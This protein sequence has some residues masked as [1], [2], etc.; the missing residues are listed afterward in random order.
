MEL[1]IISTGIFALLCIPK[2]QAFTP[3]FAGAAPVPPISISTSTSRLLSAAM[4]W[5]VAT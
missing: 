4:V 3:S 2:D 1:S 5:K